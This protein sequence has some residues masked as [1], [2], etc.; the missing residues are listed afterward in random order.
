MKDG[1][2]VQLDS[3][4][5]LKILH[6]LVHEFGEFAV[7]GGGAEEPLET[8]FRQAG[9]SRFGVEIGDLIAFRHLARGLGD[10][11]VVGA[12]EGMDLFLGDHALGFRLAHVGLAAMVGDD[13]ANLGAAQIGEALAGTQGNV[14]VDIF[15]DDI[16]RGFYGGHRVDADLGDG[17]GQ[18]IEYPDDH[19]RR[20][21]GPLDHGRQA[22]GQDGGGKRC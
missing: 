10:A 4:L 13:E 6:E 22:K 8:A 5:L 2:R 19:F 7:M 18:R 11:A 1:D 3:L 15:V 21:R 12:E 20:L 16:D 9:R 14:K 17:P